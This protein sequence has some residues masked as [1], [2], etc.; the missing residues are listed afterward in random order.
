MAGNTNANVNSWLGTFN[1]VP[2]VVKTNNRERLR[3]NGFNGYVGINDAN[4]NAMLTVGGDIMIRSIGKGAEFSMETPQRTATTKFMTR[5]QSTNIIYTLP[6]QQGT[7]NSI[8][9]NDGLGNLSWGPGLTWSFTG[10]NLSTEPNSFLGTTSNHPLRFR[11]NNTQRMV[12]G[13]N[14]NIGINNGNNAPQYDLDLYGTM[15]IRPTAG[16]QGKLIIQG[17]SNRF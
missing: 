12:I 14:G 10:D 5:A 13:E 1:Q 3:V 8:L 7:K 4:P 16:D 17:N 9:T 15:S 6:G 11:T 2:L